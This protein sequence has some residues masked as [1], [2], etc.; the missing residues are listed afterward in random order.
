LWQND[1]DGA[2]PYALQHSYGDAWNDFD[3]SILKDH[4]FTYP[5]VDGQIDTVQ[6][7]GLREGVDDV[8]YLST[9]INELA[10]TK[11]TDLPH[12]VEARTWLNDLKKRS[13]GQ[14]D[15]REVRAEMV[16]HI[17]ALKGL[18]PPVSDNAVKE[19]QVLPIESGGRAS[20]AWQTA[21]RSPSYLE[22]KRGGK[23]IEEASLALKLEHKLT[24][25]GLEAD[26]EYPFSVYSSVDADN[27]PVK[28][29]GLIN[30]SATLSL[31]ASVTESDGGV[32]LDVEVGSN[33]RSSVAV[34]WQRSLL[35]WW[36]FSSAESPG[37]DD[38]TWANE[39]RLTGDAQSVTGWFGN[40]VSL[41]G[42]G[43]FINM[44]D[45]EIPENGTATVEGWFRF[46]SFAMD[47]QINM[48]LFSGVY[49]HQS[50]N[51]LY[52]VGTNDQF[53]VASMLQLDT[54]HHIAVSWDGDAGTAVAY[55]D[56][57][58]VRVNTQGAIDEINAIDGLNIGRSVGYFGGFISAATDTF[59]GDVDEVRVWNRVLS[60]AEI[61]ASYNANLSG[62]RFAFP[63]AGK[64][65]P[66]YSLIGANAADQVAEN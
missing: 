21:Q 65:A 19:L 23:L 57:Q 5:T 34:D 43:D 49:Q 41:D 53:I 18:V 7:E 27:S 56:G 25:A 30:T 60:E 14:S 24:V 35:G 58:R 64:A 8:R 12:V 3:S 51:R 15:L 20:V 6:W 48:A 22:V 16:A 59:D 28:Y 42:S 50:N 63:H 26:K 11:G 9:L 55:I 13:L 33:Y 45:I 32:L 10:N 38:S 40:G 46:R 52:F 17:L 36:R 44:P 39:A 1:Y 29:A 66:E 37:I 54:W 47:N 2:M 62:K 31:A 61:Q 4:N